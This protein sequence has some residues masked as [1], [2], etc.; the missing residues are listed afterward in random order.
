MKKAVLIA[1][2]LIFLCGSWAVST[3]QI[4][5]FDFSR[6][7]QKSKTP[8]SS[9]QLQIPD[10]RKE[11]KEL[12]KQEDRQVLALEGSINPLEYQVGP[13]DEFKI[14]IWGELEEELEL[15]VTTE[16][17]LL[18]PYVG[19]VEVGQ[20][21]LQEAK[22]LVTSR[23]ME[24]YREAVVS[25]NL[26][27][28]RYIR[29]HVVGEVKHPGIY[30]MRAI[31]RVSDALAWADS[32]TSFADLEN[33][34]VYPHSG[35]Q[36]FQINLLKYQLEGD[37][38]NNPLLHGGEVVFIPPVALENQKVEIHG[39]LRNEGMYNIQDGQ[40]LREL[41][42]KVGGLSQNNDLSRVEV[43]RNEGA[44]LINLREGNTDMVL[45]D[46]DL[47]I[48]PRIPDSVYV[49]GFVNIPG[50]YPYYAGH[51]VMQYVGFAGGPN[52]NGSLRKIYIRRGNKC[53]KNGEIVFVQRGDVITVKENFASQ[54][55]DVISIVS[56]LATIVLTAYALNIFK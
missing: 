52:E 27:N 46:N 25:V 38:S 40:S 9:P 2:L 45:Q 35:A 39:G 41:V 51:S 7:E 21:T 48:I 26:V 6:E 22:E 34:E 12:P 8:V 4:L 47:V 5:D 15:T 55:S 32:L 1:I 42:R 53:Y 14:Y 10:V 18:I 36:K 29:V 44:T 31:S 33:I 49:E 56:P 54:L 24:N 30:E 11:K 28:V 20:K 43:Y 17:F 16:G 23:I 13:L 19:P 37:L 50:A 3:A